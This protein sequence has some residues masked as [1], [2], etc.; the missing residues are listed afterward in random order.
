MSLFLAGIVAFFASLTGRV[1]LTLL[2][3]TFLLPLRNVI[4]KLQEYPLGT[5]YLDLLFFSMIIGWIFTS[6]NRKP[7]MAPSSLNGVAI[8]LIFYITFSLMVGTVSLTGT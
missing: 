3:V 4:E 8:F 2:L 6:S 5:Q 1:N 7:F